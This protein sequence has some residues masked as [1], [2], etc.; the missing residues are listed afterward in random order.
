MVEIHRPKVL[1][2]GSSGFTGSYLLESLELGGYSATET[3]QRFALSGTGYPV[4]ICDFEH[5]SS[6]LAEIQPDFIIH[7]AAIS[8]PRHEDKQE[9]YRV[10]VNGTK[11]LLAAA[12]EQTPLLN[13]FIFAS[14]ST[15][16][17]PSSEALCE[18]SEIAPNSDYAN[19][20]ALAEE[21][22]SQFTDIPLVITR[23]FNYTGRGQQDVFLV[24]KIVNHFRNNSKQIEVGS[25]ETVRDFSD[26]RDIANY[27]VA[28]LSK[29]RPGH[30]YNLC[31][32]VGV[33][34]GSLFEALSDISKVQMDVTVTE[35]LSRYG[36]LNQVIG[37]PA[38]LFAETGVTPRFKIN[39][40]LEWMYTQ[41]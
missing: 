10:N 33:S 39:K 28:L 27:Y 34:I 35:D 21:V 23:P 17:G 32:G 36:D 14:S 37:N 5:V 9:I 41:K 20:K 2:T 22:C 25:V 16:Y 8:N 30:A 24:P 31:S 11:N 7:L 38:K 29:G 3:S 19:S 12:R 26:V 1:V 18:E 4:D 40:T 15:V 13:K 6:F